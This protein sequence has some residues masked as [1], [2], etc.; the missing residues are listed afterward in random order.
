MLQ[1]QSMLE[2]LIGP[3]N[4]ERDGCMQKRERALALISLSKA[5][6]DEQ[7]KEDRLTRVTGKSAFQRCRSEH[8]CYC[9]AQVAHD[10]LLL[11]NHLSGRRKKA[12]WL[13]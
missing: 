13:E 1:N 9:P 11:L 4:D 7:D 5:C 12:A 3:A 10:L 2:H 6:Q 8:F